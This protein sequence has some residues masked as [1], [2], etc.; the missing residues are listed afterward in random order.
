MCGFSFGLCPPQF[1]AWPS[2]GPVCQGRSGSRYPPPRPRCPRWRFEILPGHL[3]SPLCI[4]M[5]LV[6][7]NYCQRQWP[8]AG[9]FWTMMAM[10]FRIFTWFSP[11]H[12]KKKKPNSQKWA[13]VPCG[14]IWGTENSPKSPTQ[15]GR[16]W[17]AFS[18]WGSQS[19]ILITTAGRTLPCPVWGESGFYAMSR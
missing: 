15:Q 8:A 3:R 1:L 14:A 18:E 16:P 13:V 5:G 11:A 17:L 7:T 12:G 6:G 9:P 19:A 2:G 10:A 4:K